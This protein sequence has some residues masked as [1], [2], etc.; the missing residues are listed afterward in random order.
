MAGIDW[1]KCLSSLERVLRNSNGDTNNSKSEFKK[2]IASGKY[3]FLNNIITSMFISFNWFW[4][5]LTLV[6]EREFLRAV[7]IRVRS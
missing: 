6:N 4:E 3:N 5:K 2:Y 1:W 7:Q